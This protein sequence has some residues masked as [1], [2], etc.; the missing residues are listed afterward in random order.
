MFKFL[1][2]DVDMNSLEGAQ[3]LTSD[4]FEN[5]HTRLDEK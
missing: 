2:Y 3:L 4:P 5:L 1:V